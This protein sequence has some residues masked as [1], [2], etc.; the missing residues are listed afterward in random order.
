MRRRVLYALPMISI[1]LACRTATHPG[2][3]VAGAQE[4]RDEF[5][6]GTVQR[7]IRVG[8]SGAEV[9]AVLGPPNAVTADEERREVWIYDRVS[10]N[11]AYTT[12]S[13]GVGVLV[14]DAAQGAA[15]A[16]AI[17]RTLTVIVKFDPQK[18]VRDFAYYTSKS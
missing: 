10:T 11:G 3:D 4:A 17:R 14:L 15:A 9:A 6:E 12:S 2:T 5:R 7:E 16:S 1:A 18:R 13:G 8:M